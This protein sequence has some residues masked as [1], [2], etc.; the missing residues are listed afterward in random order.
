MLYSHTYSW[1][2]VISSD[3]ESSSD[4]ERED[5]SD[6]EDGSWDRMAKRKRMCKRQRRVSRSRSRVRSKAP[7]CKQKCSFPDCVN[8]LYSCQAC[9]PACPTPTTPSLAS[10]AMHRAAALTYT[11]M[12]ILVHIPSNLCCVLAPTVCW[13]QLF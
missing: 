7:A 9:V 10:L 11:Y 12:H 6:E 1:L 4:D 3:S 13:C 8:V 5:L 2:Q